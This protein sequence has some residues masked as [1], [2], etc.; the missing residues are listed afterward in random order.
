LYF[1][2]ESKSSLFSDELRARESAQITCGRA[3][4][5]TL[6]VRESPVDYIVAS[7]VD[8]VLSHA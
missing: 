5:A 3:H 6:N 8:D 7:S 1:V 4:F 2:V